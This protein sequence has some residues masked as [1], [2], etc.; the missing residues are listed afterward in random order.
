MPEEAFASAAISIVLPDISAHAVE[1]HFRMGAVPI[2]GR[3][4]KEQFLL[5]LRTISEED[6]PVIAERY[7]I[8]LKS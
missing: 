3:I 5:D 8:L 7:K 4:S 6:F 1:Q 2:I